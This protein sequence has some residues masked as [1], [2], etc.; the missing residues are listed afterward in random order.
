MPI[1]VVAG[2]DSGCGS[3]SRAVSG[4]AEG[5]LE[6]PRARA[7]RRCDWLDDDAAHS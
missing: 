3:T 1:H 4:G 5:A 6:Q 2:A 7:G